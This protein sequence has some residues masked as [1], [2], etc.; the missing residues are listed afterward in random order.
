MS[1]AAERIKLRMKEAKVTVDDLAPAIKKDRTTIY[2]YLNGAI[3]NIPINVLSAIAQELHTT[4]DYLMGWTDDPFGKES[5]DHALNRE[6]TE[7]TNMV[8]HLTAAGFTETEIPNV[9]KYHS[10]PEPD[11]DMINAMIDRFAEK[12]K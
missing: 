1:V 2:R 5:F 3:E 10:L 8:H 7:Y 6:Y 12:G 11:K 9:V 4:P